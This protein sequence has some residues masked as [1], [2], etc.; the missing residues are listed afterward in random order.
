MARLRILPLPLP[1]A[2]DGRI[3]PGR[4]PFVVV[5]DRLTGPEAD[6]LRIQPGAAEAIGAVGM[7]VFPPGL[8]I[9]LPGVDDPDLM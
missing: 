7:M 1:H 3:E 4:P 8:S 9:D 6:I 5:I 2:A